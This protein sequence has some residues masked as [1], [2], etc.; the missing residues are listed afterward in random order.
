MADGE[1]PEPPVPPPSPAPVG[2]DRVSRKDL[3]ALAKRLDQMQTR[4]AD[5]SPNDLQPIRSQLDTLAP[6][7]G[8]VQ[9]LTTK[10][11]DVDRRLAA[12]EKT[13]ASLRGKLGTARKEEQG[14]AGQ[15]FET[16]LDRAIADFHEG[17]YREARQLFDDLRS[18]H[19]DDARVWYYSALTTGLTSGAWDTTA[20]RYAREGMDRERA[21]QP[22]K[23]K[24]DAALAGLTTD[25]GKDWIEA[26]RR[27][28]ASS[29]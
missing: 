20:E 16:T 25:T 2:G 11:A 28:A 9:T 26:F 1:Q 29:Q 13:I 6:L 18:S 22:G 27:R 15:E 24:I 3:D 5:Q 7:P 23:A 21:G 12:A 19:P 17:R 14:L 4:L 8:E 10:V